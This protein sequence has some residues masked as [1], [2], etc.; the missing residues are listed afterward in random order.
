MQQ[1]VNLIR[2]RLDLSQAS[3]FRIDESE[4]RA[5]LAAS[6]GEVGHQMLR[7]GYWVE[8]G[9]TSAVGWC[10]ANAQVSI[11]MDVSEEDTRSD[12]LLLPETRS[13]IALPLL[14][15]GRVIGA[16]D[17][18]ATKREA[19]SQEEIALLQTIADQL[20]VAI[21]N[22]QLFAETQ[23]RLEELE[24]VQRTY[25]RDQ[26]SKFMRAQATPLYE[27]TRP[28]VIPLAD[29]APLGGFGELSRAIEQAMTQ[30]E[31]VVQSEMG[32]GAEQA[33]LVAPLRLRGEI[34]GTLG[35]HETERGRR[36]TDD[37]V[38]LI[39]TIATQM[40]LAVENARLF[41]EAQQRAGEQEE[42]ARIAALAGS[43][44][45][46]DEL[47]ARL[48]EGAVQLL[49]AQVGVLLLLDED[50]KA[51]IDRY[52]SREGRLRLTPGEW[53]VPL[54]TPG[55]EQSIFSRGGTYY[56]N[57]AQTDPNI[58]PAYRPLVEALGA[59]SFCGVAL[60]VRD[61][62]IGELYVADRPGGFGPEQA[63]LLGTV[64]GHVVSAIENA[65]LFEEANTRADE[66]AILN[67]LAQAFTAA[68]SVEEVVEEAY[69]GASRLLRTHNF[70][71]GL[72]DPEKFE[73]EF[74]F[75]VSES[76]EDKQITTIPADQGLTGYVVQNRT[77]VLIG[78]NMSEWLEER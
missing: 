69:R 34:I 78:E 6:T 50:E 14:S 71:V 35:L 72:Y 44:L 22:A 2:E 24:A 56:T 18:Q 75:D 62:S 64:T 40:A 68:T 61:R 39:D 4:Q 76:E 46:L 10:T 57:R 45:D 3:L 60:R 27:R 74:I 42:L 17:V 43:T 73:I 19:F 49:G 9:G 63:Q 38:A 48:V 28:D 51:L 47:L 65:R 23:A 55:F 37:E 31:V 33:A 15:H 30:Q 20:A 5:V 52:L 8:V 77:S 54:D 25:V 70:Y 11:A 67:E 59:E 66:L 13:N 32:D 7:R 53:R 29:T 41:E 36:W 26:W 1:V 16:L 58:L 12:D 21:D